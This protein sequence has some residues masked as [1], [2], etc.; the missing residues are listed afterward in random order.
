MPE[1]NQISEELREI[2][3]LLASAERISVWSVPQGYF[4]TLPALILARVSKGNEVAIEL[5]SIAPLLASLSKAP[6]YTV[7]TGYFDAPSFVI[8][9]TKPEGVVVPFSPVRGWIKYAAAAVVIGL[10]VMAAWIYTKPSVTQQSYNSQ[11][12]ASVL[13]Q[14]SEADLTA[15]LNQHERLVIH[16]EQTN[17]VNETLPE[18]DDHIEM[19]SDEEM[20]QYL[21]ENSEPGLRGS[22]KKNG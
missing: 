22:G 3:P 12:L 18:M 17:T 21:Q 16:G 14:V 4:D 19:L 9:Q 2:S 7:P 15:Y 13:Q 5:E 6:V 1:M 8:P 10:M 11:D 20:K